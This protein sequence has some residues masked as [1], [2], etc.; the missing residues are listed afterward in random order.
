MTIQR[1]IELLEKMKMQ[2]GDVEVFFDCQ[3]CGKS[4]RPV[5]I[6]AVAMIQCA[7]TK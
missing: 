2:H 4:T 3:C 1:A 7:P 6:V 5:A